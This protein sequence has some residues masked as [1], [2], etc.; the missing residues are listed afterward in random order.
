M[1]QIRKVYA[2]PPSETNIIIATCIC[3]INPRGC[4]AKTP[5]ACPTQEEGNRGMYFPPFPCLSYPLQKGRGHSSTRHWPLPSCIG[6]GSVVAS[7]FCKD[8]KKQAKE[9]SPPGWNRQSS[10]PESQWP[11][12]IKGEQQS[13]HLHAP[14][15]HAR[16]SPFN[17]A[18]CIASNI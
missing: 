3:L 15:L 16:A 8:V 10:S 12:Q 14:L 7:M 18:C 17:R 4:S 13:C 2:W 6:G 1:S 5:P 9:K 11:C